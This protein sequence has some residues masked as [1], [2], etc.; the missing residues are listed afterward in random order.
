M[1]D[2]SNDTAALIAANRARR[3]RHRRRTVA[4][5]FLNVAALAGAIALDAAMGWDD[6]GRGSAPFIIVLAGSIS[7]GLL[8]SDARRQDGLERLL[9]G[10]AAIAAVTLI[11]LYQ[12]ASYALWLSDDSYA[13][14]KPGTT[15]MVVGISLMTSPLLAEIR[16]RRADEVA[17]L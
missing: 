5:R 4:L 10:R 14:A 11:A 7:F 15:L 2:S 9:V 13:V 1:T 8:W 12:T 17:D 6:D 3:H 16:Q